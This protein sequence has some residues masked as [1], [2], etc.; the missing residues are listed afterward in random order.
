MASQRFEIGRRI[1]PPRFLLF[2]GLIVV[3]VPIAIGR[4]GWAIG[5]M[6]AFDVAAGAF[7]LSIIP[8]LGDRAEDMRRSA[9]RNDANRLGL[10]VVTGI[11]SITVL[12]AVSS[13]LLQEGQRNHGQITLIVAT[14]ALS[15]T[16]ST[17][18]YALH[19]A[20]M[21]YVSEQGR[22][23]G[24]VTFPD[25]EQPDYWDFIYLATCLGMTFQVSDMSLTSGRMR[26]V[27]TFHCLAAFVFNLGIVAFTINVLGGG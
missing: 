13:V 14:L 10:L 17:I 24:G 18:I 20:H 26:R 27:V 9:E 16:F 3:G 11:V 12:A 25:T 2:L 6:L 7:L 23:A 22:D 19:Y 15:W 5:S 8:L 21:F 1:A 4:F